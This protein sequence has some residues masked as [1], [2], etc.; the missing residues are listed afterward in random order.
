MVIPLLFF[1]MYFGSICHVLKYI[2]RVLGGVFLVFFGFV[3][4]SRLWPPELSGIFWSD[5]VVASRTF[6]DILE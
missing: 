3:G 2:S 4:V 6:G 5:L 1:G